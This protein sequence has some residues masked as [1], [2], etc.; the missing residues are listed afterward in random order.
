[1]PRQCGREQSWLDDERLKPLL[2]SIG[3]GI[4]EVDLLS[5]VPVKFT[6]RGVRCQDE[7]DPVKDFIRAIQFRCVNKPAQFRYVFPVHGSVSD[8]IISTADMMASAESLGFQ[9]TDGQVRE[10][11]SILGLPML[12]NNRHKL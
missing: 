11:T 9:L 5:N 12:N 7:R 8:G 4:T 6:A 3:K 10:V 1:M 2:V